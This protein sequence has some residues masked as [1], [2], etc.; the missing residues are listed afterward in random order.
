M[1]CI[2]SPAGQE[3]LFQ[4]IGVPVA[5]RTTPPP[6]PDAETMAAFKARAEAL[7]VNYKTEILEHA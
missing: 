2:C 6:P 1:L 3:G 5:G 4:E 7:A